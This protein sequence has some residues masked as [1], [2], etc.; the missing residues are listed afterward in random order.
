MLPLSTI[1][2]SSV[3]KKIMTGI[4]GL[5]LCLFIIGHLLGNIN[6][7]IGEDAFNLYTHKLESLGGFLYILEA[8]IAVGFVVHAVVGISIWIKKREARPVSY[9]VVS[10]AGGSSK[11]SLS[12]ITMIYTGILLLIFLILHLKTFKYGPQYT[13]YI[14]GVGEVRDLYRLVIEVYQSPGYV[15][16]YVVLMIMLGFHLRHGFWS[17]FQS[18]GVTHPRFKGVIFTT[19]IIFSIVMAVGFLVMPVWIYFTN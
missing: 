11:K 12:S 7:F 18:L 2:W 15:I 5:A 17:A 3:G 14:D 6:L 9:D 4:T 13:S 19:G 8:L 1:V 10:N 16:F